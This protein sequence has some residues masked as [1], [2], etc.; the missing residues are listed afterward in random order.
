MSATPALRPPHKILDKALRL[1]RTGQIADAIEQLGQLVRQA[2]D[3][4]DGRFL[5]GSFLAQA[6]RLDEARVHLG[7][8]AELNPSSPQILN[9]LGNV[10]RILG[11]NAA[12]EACYRQV[13][14]LDPAFAP[15]WLNLGFVCVRLGRWQDALDAF[16]AAG[17]DHGDDPDALCAIGEARRALGQTA[18]AIDSYERAR[19]ADPEDR[20]NVSTILAALRGDAPP[21]RHSDALVVDT[22]RAKAARWDDEVRRDGDSYFGPQ[23][24]ARL[25][26]GRIASGDGLAVLDLGCGT[27]A[28]AE[29]L[30]PLASR[31]VGVDLSPDML[32][33][34]RRK[35]GYTELVEAEIGRYLEAADTPF[36]LVV[37][38]GVLIVFSRLDGILA[39]IA[40][41][42]APGGRAAITLYRSD[43]ADIEVRHNHHF[44]H[45]RAYLG[46]EAAAAG[47]VVETVAE[48][49]HEIAEGE[50]QPG[51]A[52]L[53]RR[54]A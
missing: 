39:R 51:F 53:L 20:R 17:V 19:R 28:C 54:P 4:L 38:A 31:L 45:S 24:V 37:A 36:D 14:G 52:V 34:A 11:E 40:A 42:L 18:A 22:Y 21:D 41:R 48:V 35:G 47:L 7:R 1:H 50:A 13:V 44:G 9:N 32:E 26:E 12:A 3:H 49:V 15:G 5:L 27:G 6:G 8:A 33:V 16:A 30:A 29:F 2:P 43:G 23:L 25:L 10:Q 46:R